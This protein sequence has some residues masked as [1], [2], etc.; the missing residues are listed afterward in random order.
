MSI[1]SNIRAGSAYVEVTADTGRL[2]KGLSQAQAQLR[3]FGQTC[4]NVGRD[5]LVLSAIAGF[6]LE[7]AIG[8]FGVTVRAEEQQV[9]EVVVGR[10]PVEVVD[11]E[12]S[13]V[14]VPAK[15]ALRTD[16]LLQTGPH[17]LCWF[18]PFVHLDGSLVFAGCCFNVRRWL[19]PNIHSLV[20]SAMD[21]E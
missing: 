3:A 10:V 8:E 17:P 19:G 1:V 20:P 12:L 2:N 16:L 13:D 18:L 14:F 6:R 9:L 21:V 7:R 5:L 15:R 4:T 11:L